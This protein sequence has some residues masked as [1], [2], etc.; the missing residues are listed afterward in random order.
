[1]RRSWKFEL[2]GTGLGLVTWIA[3]SLGIQVPAFFRWSGFVL[4]M[5]LIA[6]PAVEWLFQHAKERRR[7]MP[8]IGMFVFG[9]AFIGCAARYFEAS[10][11]ESSGLTT[12]EA[13]T[14]APTPA[15]QN[16][17]LTTNGLA[18][19]NNLLSAPSVMSNSVSDAT[20]PPPV[21]LGDKIGRVRLL[22]N[23]DEGTLSEI[24]HDS[25]IKSV[26]VIKR[27][28]AI[29]SY[30]LQAFEIKVLFRWPH[31]PFK[32]ISSGGAD[33][34]ILPLTDEGKGN[35][36]SSTI[37]ESIMSTSLNGEKS[38]ELYIDFYNIASEQ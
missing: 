35:L 5:G 21:T 10:I 12:Q 23:T 7:M 26:V 24:S 28:G 30:Y 4:G 36:F 2:S 15:E 38:G 11:Q 20:F 29:S 8:L 22:Y 13:S 6:A 18:T 25:S 34:S 32:A 14:P 27:S 19:T 9:L 33:L 3:P 31:G 37:T 17:S 1:M 16:A